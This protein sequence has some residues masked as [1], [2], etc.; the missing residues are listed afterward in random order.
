MKDF[1]P[2]PL[3]KFFGGIYT[4]WKTRREKARLLV[5]LRGDTVECNLCA[6]RG[7]RFTDDPWHAG[8]VCP[9]CRSQVRHRMVAAMFDGFA[10]TQGCNEET[11][12][13]GKDVLHF[14][15]ERQL[16]E[17]VR[18]ASRI[19]VTADFD[20]GDCDLQL[21]MSS[22]P[23]V[24]DAS[25][26]TVIACD[27][28]EHVPD[29]AAAM[30]ELRRVLRSGGSVLVTVPQKDPPASTDEDPTVTEAAARTAR[31]GQKDHVRMYG[32]DFAARLESAGFK[33]RVLSASAFPKEQ[34]ERHVLEPPCPNPS[35]LATNQRRIYLALAV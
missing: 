26:D 9:V 34:V 31:F 17:R 4:D 3:R 25:F 14:A 15:P 13:A 23:G 18:S 27:V 8:T 22:M 21:D 20:R 35:P 16:R 12:I 2:L 7:A 30:R 32:D 33:V 10:A 11:L 24:G 28:L 1:V 19:Y 29:D 5:S 6:W